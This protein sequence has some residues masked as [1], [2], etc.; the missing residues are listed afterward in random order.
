MTN[1]SMLNK[2]FKPRYVTLSVLLELSLGCTD[3]ATLQMRREN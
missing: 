3:R 2:L 1:C